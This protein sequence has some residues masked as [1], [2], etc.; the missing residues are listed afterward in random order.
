M[1]RFIIACAALSLLVLAGCNSGPEK[2]AEKHFKKSI[3]S[4]SGLATESLKVTT[5]KADEKKAVVKV[6]ASLK[7]SEEL[8]LV[9][10]DGKWVVK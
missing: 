9:N 2:V 4:H 7:Y 1:K 6:E 10:E 8:T 5:V 3:D